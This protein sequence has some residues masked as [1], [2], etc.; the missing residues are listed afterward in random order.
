MTTQEIANRL[1]E[2]CRAGQDSQAQAEL[3][4]ADAESLEPAYAPNNHAKGL[5]A[6]HQKGQEFYSQ[7]EEMHSLQVSEPLVGDSYFSVVFTM[8]LTMKG[9]PRQTMA[10]VGLYEV[11]DGK[12]VKEQFFY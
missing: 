4:T 6:I 2:L 10:E 7:V 5:E 11:R 3:Y 9:Q 1:V 12:V 8:D